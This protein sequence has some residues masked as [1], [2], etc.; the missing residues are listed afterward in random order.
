MDE[1]KYIE[2]SKNRFIKILKSKLT[3]ATIG[4]IDAIENSAFGDLWDS[5]DKQSV[6]WQKEWAQV[7][8]KILTNGN[9]QMRALVKELN[10]YSLC[11]NRYSLK[12]PVFAT[13]EEYKQYLKEK[14][15][16]AKE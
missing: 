8:S 1:D 4:A 2:K 11:W 16:N 5:D 7:R 13:E 9:N 15:E 6:F 14:K 10:Q 3:T 12:L